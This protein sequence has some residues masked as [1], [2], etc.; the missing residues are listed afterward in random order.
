MNTKRITLGLVLDSVNKNGLDK[1]IDFFKQDYHIDDIIVFSKDPLLASI[2]KNYGVLSLYHFKFY[3][4][5]VVFFALDDYIQYKGYSLSNDIYL[6]LENESLQNNIESINRYT[7]K[8]TNIIIQNK[9]TNELELM[10]AK[11]L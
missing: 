5:F 3:K 2:D 6:Y 10:N 7:L 8:N 4:G 11:L 1:T 9:H